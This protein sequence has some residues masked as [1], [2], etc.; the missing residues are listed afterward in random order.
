M[1]ED[2]GLLNA[3]KEEHTGKYISTKI[4]FKNS[5][6]EDSDRLEL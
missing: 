1:K 5:E 2:S 6:D 3:T 4:I